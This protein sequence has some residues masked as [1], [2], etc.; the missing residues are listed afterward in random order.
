MATNEQSL[1]LLWATKMPLIQLLEM[2]SLIVVKGLFVC[3]IKIRRN[4]TQTF[5]LCPF[6]P[7]DFKKSKAAL[8][9]LR[10]VC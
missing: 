5:L 6:G 10:M 4:E 9:A 8:P 1:E 3:C 2:L 7:F